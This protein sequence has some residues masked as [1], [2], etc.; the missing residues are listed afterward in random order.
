MAGVLDSSL[1]FDEAKEK[2]ADCQPQA[3]PVELLRELGSIAAIVALADVTIYRGAG[4]SG[5][6][7]F[8]VAMPLLLLIGM[9]RP[10]LRGSFWLLSTMLLVL[11]L[12]MIWL[13][14]ALAVASGAALLVA[15][16]LALRGR[17]PYFLE[18]LFVAL[19]LLVAGAFGIDTYSRTLS[20]RGPRLT[21]SLWLNLTLPVGAVV[22]FGTIFV[23]ANPDLA[24]SVAQQLERSWNWL[25]D[26]SS[27]FSENWLEVVF[28]LA[29]A[30]V[31]IGLLR[32]VWPHRDVVV[33]PPAAIDAE[34]IERPQL[35]SLFVPLRNMLLGVIVLF[36][37]YLVFE[38]QTLWFREFPRGFHYSG[39]A[40]RGAAWLTFA[41]ALATLVLSLIFRSAVLRDPRLARLRQLA[42]IW[43]AQNWLLAL[44][45]YH[46]MY[47][48][49]DFNGMTRMRTIGLFGIT[50][51]VAGFVLVLW[52][53]IHNRSFGW[54]IQRQ[55]WALAIA[56]YVFALTPVDTLIHSY[57]VRRIMA[58]DVAAS[59]QISVHP[60]SPEGY[61]VLQPL[62]NCSD[63][64]IREGIRALLAEQEIAAEQRAAERAK[65]GWTSFQ[66]SDRLLLRKLRDGHAVWADYSGYSQTDERREALDRF[67]EYAYQWF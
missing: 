46:R 21:R 57:N 58:G 63:P 10:L 34:I 48:Y 4:F 67:H 32:P 29:A 15:Y 9:A 37:V 56:V 3:L 26:W 44:T 59:V 23:L 6:A 38:F 13:G 61:L 14:T 20:G 5:L 60:N 28:W 19:Q 17:R 55:L 22:L 33:A 25:I 41:L 1:P 35:S 49:I 43:S 64:I 30:Y 40:H 66:L 36:A 18:V 8:F 31:A 11:G 53:I 47:I 2:I 42:W 54:L 62:T 52:K 45:V 50:T 51:V 65:L 27:R 39:Y 24:Q 7:L 16:C 12:R